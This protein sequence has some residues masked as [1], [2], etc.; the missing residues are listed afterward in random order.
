MN[1]PTAEFFEALPERGEEPLLE[2][3][4]GV[5]RFD[6]THGKKTD[7]WLVTMTRGRMRVD[8]DNGDADCILRADKGLFDEIVQGKANAT[9]AL[10]RGAVSLTVGGPR[11]LEVLML[12]QRLFPGPPAGWRQDRLVATGERR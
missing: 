1:D 10:L 2:K 3:A 11:Q 8:Q 9:A 6:L 7:H 5:L 12:F 4:S